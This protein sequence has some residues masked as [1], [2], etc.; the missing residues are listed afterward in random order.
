MKYELEILLTIKYQGKIIIEHPS[1]QPSIH[2]TTHLPQPSIQKYSIRMIKV[3]EYL[4][5]QTEMNL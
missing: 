5:N 2:I 1:P 3:L 4:S